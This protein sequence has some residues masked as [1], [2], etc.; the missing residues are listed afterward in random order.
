MSATLNTIGDI[1]VQQGNYEDAL[2]YFFRSL[3]LSEEMG[4]SNG[5]AASLNSI[6]TV[7]Q[8]QADAAKEIG[9]TE[10]I[11]IKYASAINYFERSL[12]I[13]TEIDAKP[14]TI[15]NFISLGDVHSRLGDSEAALE[16]YRRSLNTAEE[17]AYKIGIIQSANNIGIV[18][19]TRGDSSLAKGETAKAATQYNKAMESSRRALKLAK[20]LGTVTEIMKASKTLFEL[21]KIKEKY[22]PALAMYELY[23]ETKS[24]IESEQNQR[25]VIRQKYKYEYEK[26]AI[27]D[28]I[29]SAERQKLQV[30]QL[31]E[32]KTR[33]LF[34][35]V[36]LGLLTIFIAIIFN[37]FLVTNKQKRIIAEQNRRL[38]VAAAVAEAA[39]KSKSDFLAN[40]S[41]EIRTP[42]NVIIGMT[43]LAMKTELNSKQTSYI[44]KTS[45]SAKNLLRILNDI[46][47]FSKIEANKLEMESIDFN[48]DTVTRDVLDLI[49]FKANDKDIKVSLNVANNVPKSLI[50]DPLRLRQVL[51]NLLNNA[52]KFS[53]EG[54]AIVFNI[55]LDSQSTDKSVLMFTVKDQGIGI[56]YEQQ[57]KLFTPFTQA[58]G[59]TTRQYGG[60]GL[61]LS[62]SQKIVQLMGGDISFESKEGI[63]STFRF[64]A[65]F[66]VQKVI[67]AKIVPK[68]QQGSSE[69]VNDKEGLRN[70]KILL[71]EDNELNQEMLQE[72]LTLAGMKVVIANNGQEALDSLTKESFDGILMD[73]QMPVMNGYE[74]TRH[75]REQDKFMTLP[76][77]ALTGNTME[78]ERQKVLAIGMND[79][80]TKPIDLDT[81][82]ATMAK[83][84]SPRQIK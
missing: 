81:M 44:E 52:V 29:R 51:T 40:M 23:I 49:K 78:S 1:Y 43:H 84:I 39:N 36:I 64:T 11:S 70:A 50:G 18:Y 59:S 75:I 48:L 17:I 60:T 77:I 54:D 47:D 61:G 28:S 68:T 22:M 3:R 6:G 16:Y 35:M 20:E 76:I 83:W 63:G 57:K 41:H 24:S 65:G 13:N 45:I 4:S 56:S 72:L 26:R 82:F 7:Y 15:D 27:A 12:A 21:Y 31:S 73:C 25:E 69:T 53:S 42:M 5:I 10:M 14:G 74:A 66:K 58:D 80:I 2:G 33:Q 8:K 34:L 55:S 30:A 79:Y 71:V 67:Q 9:N 32:S 62:I 46:L 38:A 19:K 37:R